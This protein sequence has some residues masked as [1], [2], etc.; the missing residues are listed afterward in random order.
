MTAKSAHVPPLVLQLQRIGENLQNVMLSWAEKWQNFFLPCDTN[1]LGKLHSIPSYPKSNSTY[2]HCCRHFE[3]RVKTLRFVSEIELRFCQLVN[4]SNCQSAP[5]LGDTCPGLYLEFSCWQFNVVDFGSL[6]KLSM[7]LS[8][9]DKSGVWWVLE[10][11]KMAL[12]T[13]WLSNWDWGVKR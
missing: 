11:R 1:F 12:R 13:A 10:K 3:I 6:W 8:K 2:L 5:K 7:Q 4:W 9:L